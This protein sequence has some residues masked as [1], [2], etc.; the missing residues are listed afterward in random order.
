MGPLIDHPAGALTAAGRKR[1]ELARALATQPRLLLLDEV[2]AA[3]NPTEIA[4]LV[5]LV[6]AI[7]D[8]GVTLLLTEHVMQAV[9]GLAEQVYVLA[10]GRIIAEGAPTTIVADPAVIESYLGHGAAA[11]LAG[12]AHA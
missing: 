11:R 5:A 4:E 8:E 12:A 7:R 3:L 2:M 10:N 9:M 6:R 1:L